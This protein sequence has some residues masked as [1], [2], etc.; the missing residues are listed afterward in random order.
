MILQKQYEKINFLGKDTAVA[1]YLNPDEYTTA[2]GLQVD[3]PIFPFGCNKS[4]FA[5]VKSALS[6]RFSVIEGPPGTGKTQTILNII[7]NLVLN[8]KTVQV[9]SNNNSAI[10]NIIE[11]LASPTY[12]L[13]FFVASLGKE[14]KKQAFIRN[15]TGLLPDFRSFADDQ[16]NAPEF[17]EEVTKQS[18]E[19]GNI[20]DMQNRLAVLKQEKYRVDLESKH[21]AETKVCQNK[22]VPMKKILCSTQ[23][24]QLLVEC[25]GIFNAP[26]KP[27]II[28]RILLRIR[29]GV[30]AKDVLKS[31]LITMETAILSKFYEVRKA[32][33]DSGIQFLEEKLKNTD[34]PALI[35]DFTCKSL[36]CFRSML[37]Q[38]YKRITRPVFN[39]NDL[40]R[41]PDEFLKEYPV[42]LSTTYTAR[43]SLG[44]NALFDYVIMDEA[45]QV[46]VAT[47]TLALSC[48]KNAVI[49]GDTK[50]LPNVV[51]PK[52][53]PVLQA[54]FDSAGIPHAYNFNENSFLDSVFS[55]LENRIPRTVL[56][57]H[58]RCNPQII[59]YCNHKFYQDDLIV[60]T[61]GPE[62]ALKL[63]T[64]RAGR[65]ARERTNL[66]QAEII[67]DE[68]LPSLHCPS[69]EI[70]IIT[71]YRNQAD[72]I[73][74]VINAPA[75]DVATIHKFQGR[76]K[77]V[78][79]FSTVD[80]IVT[81]FSDDPDLLNVAVSRA[82]KKFILVASEEEQPQGSNVGDLIGY[83]QYNNCEIVH[84][85]I[86]SVFD[87]LYT[88]YKEERLAYLKRHK[89]IS[90][91]DSENLMFGLIQDVLKTSKAALGVVA[92]Q[93]L[94]QLIR[95][96][97]QLSDEEERFIKT[98]LSHL[99]FLVYNKVTK[100]PVLAIEV[101]G[102]WYHKAG[103]R[104]AERDAMKDHIL[105]VYQIPMM[106][107]ATNGSREKEKLSNKLETIIKNMN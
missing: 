64:T 104:Q 33:I 45:S 85:T 105:E 89:R 78:I 92:H 61:E 106:R 81:E 4:Q 15:Q 5:A 90:E 94:Y 43:S 37:A 99:D 48:A 58:Y 54:I 10:E 13:E 35:S 25:Q 6:N 101:D 1:V 23:L 47:G 107:F 55:L 95:D 39:K 38:R 82:K 36:A 18:S 56:R 87:Y 83:I 46:D 65:H 80:D 2:S 14:E 72:S 16:Y 31:D 17:S 57:E 103:T 97:S 20:F 60:M 34:A 19:L 42:V 88:Q 71:P 3:A 12:N 62:N 29:Y 67:R 86:G 41:N 66:R 91:F 11:K 26:K 49:V 59:G 96:Y 50:Q 7:A 27:G 77:D 102:Y 76:E 74:Q 79:V 9:V 44:K 100:K 21:F 63:V 24:M 70:G 98:G 52:E 73:R 28:A 32:E 75:I 93:P 68:I 84:S 22:A 69:E 30:S 51:P 8:G 40:W 53:K